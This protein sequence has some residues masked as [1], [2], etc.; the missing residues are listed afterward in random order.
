MYDAAIIGCG[1]VGAAIAYELSRLDA[2]VIILEK[3][4][5]VCMGA[6]RANSAI[7]HAGY[8]PEPGTLMARL[9]V[10]GAQMAS[11]LCPRLDVPYKKVGSL[12]LGFDQAD[13]ETLKKLY[14]RGVANGVPGIRLMSREEV[15]EAEPQV[16]EAVLGA[17][18]APGAA[19]VNPW[20]YGL[21]LAEV[22]VRNGVSLRRSAPVTAVRGLSDG[23]EIT[24]GGN[25]VTARF[26]INAA[27]L[28][29]DAIH[30]MAAEPSFE[31]LPAKGEYYLLDKCEGT[32][33]RHVLFQCPNEKGKGVLVAPTVHGNLIAGPNAVPSS[34]DDTSNTAEGLE[35]VRTAAGKSVPG[36]SWRSNIRNFA[37]VRA[38]SGEADFIIG[39]AAPGFFDAA[40]IK[41]PGLSAAP[42][43]GEY[44]AGLLINAGFSRTPRAGWSDSRRKVRIAHMTAGEKSRMISENPAYGRV[45]CRC[46]TIT[47]GEIIDALHSVI[48]PCSVDGIKRRAGSAMGRC[49]GGFCTPRVVEIM[50]RELGIRPNEILQDKAGSE[51]LIGETK[52]GG[53]CD[54]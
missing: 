34:R 30:N 41:S 25:T 33:A 18:Y 3:E 53:F 16:S 8:D 39:E 19:I 2:N 12:V 11:V 5:D 32:R 29:S 37:G 22:A 23:W 50:A 7:I 20:E 4:N 54:V 44:V 9:N 27:G 49:Q 10:R 13:M 14:R 24:A 40:G 45:I 17:L 26:V 6:T 15:L 36:I 47:E 1:I 28:Y 31:I 21:A 38:N 52:Q 43:I 46:E 48:P 42:A 35:F 51:I